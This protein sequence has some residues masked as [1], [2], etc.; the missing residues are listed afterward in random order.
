MRSDGH[1]CALD[2]PSLIP[3][4]SSKMS[5]DERF[6]FCLHRLT[7]SLFGVCVFESLCCEMW[8]LETYLSLCNWIKNSKIQQKPSGTLEFGEKF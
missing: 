1:K 3:E 6:C 4:V 8:R 7:H 2:E 5:L